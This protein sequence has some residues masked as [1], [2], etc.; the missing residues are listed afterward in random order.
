MKPTY[1][2]LEKRIKF[3]EIQIA[4]Q[5]LAEETL[6]NRVD[7]NRSLFENNPVEIITVDREARVTGFNPARKSAGRRLP[8]L[9]QVMY[10]SFASGHEIDMY[11]ELMDCIP[12][13][14]HKRVP[15]TEMQRP[16]SLQQYGLF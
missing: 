3:L 9:G 1:E 14:H 5:R 15:A 16:V 8:R 4:Q 2:D 11:E 7:H 13:Q 12:K 6:Q 10:R